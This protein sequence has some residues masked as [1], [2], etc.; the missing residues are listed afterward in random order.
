MPLTYWADSPNPSES[1]NDQLT[2]IHQNAV[3][4]AQVARIIDGL[5]VYPAEANSPSQVVVPKEGNW[6]FLP[7]LQ[8]PEASFSFITTVDPNF[9]ILCTIDK[10]QPS[11][12]IRKVTYTWQYTENGG[13]SYLSIGVLEETY[14]DLTTS[15]YPLWPLV[16]KKW[17]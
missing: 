12:S 6:S 9:W 13:T 8:G 7:G 16:E 10:T 15:G 2:R 3:I 5:R 11:S 1:Y 14:Q 4:N 17:L